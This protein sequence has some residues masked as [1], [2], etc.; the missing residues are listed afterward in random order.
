MQN[1]KPQT[2]VPQ[3]HAPQPHATTPQSGNS[4]TPTGT[5]IPFPIGLSPMEGPEPSTLKPVT[6]GDLKAMKGQRVR[7]DFVKIRVEIVN[8]AAIKQET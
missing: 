4:T 6:A 5:P 2:P 1:P 8:D 3:T 7:D